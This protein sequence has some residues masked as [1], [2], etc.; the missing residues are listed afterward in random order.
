M[1]SVPPGPDGL[2]LVGNT[3][4]LVR[5]QGGYLERAVQNY[6]PVVSIRMLGAGEVIV[7]ADPDLV[8]SVCFGEEYTKAALA[9]ETLEDLLG[10]GLLLATGEEWRRRRDM[11]QPVFDPD[12]LETY[13]PSMVDRSRA[14]VDGLDPG[15]TYD[16]G[17]EMRRLTFSILLDAVFGTDVE[18]DEYNLQQAA[19]HLLEP[20]KPRKQPIAYTVP[21]WVPIPMWRRY[22]SAIEEFEGVIQT[23][24]DSRDPGEGADFLSMLLTVSDEQGVLTE[25][26]LRDEL[27][28]ML[29]AGH[30]TTATAL[31]FTWQLLGTHPSVDQRLEAELDEVLGEG[32]PT[33]ADL[34]DLEYTEHVVREAMRLYPPVPA[35][36]R[37]PTEPTELGGHQIAEGTTVAPSQWVVHHD[38]DL[39]ED[40]WEF[41]PGRWERRPP[42]DRHRFAYFPF[43]GGPR[44]CI[45]EQFAMMEAKL[46]VATVANRY[47]FRAVDDSPLDPAVSIV[48]QPT[49]SIEIL[50]ERRSATGGPQA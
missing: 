21:M 10:E 36:G 45:G 24:L 12:R 8:E 13:V 40:P 18:Y 47:R 14:F 3:L 33:A 6:G 1:A 15:R 46:V 25:T 22:H 49:R 38:P 32:V 4:G 31:T 26:E 2:P 23:L 34:A 43:G 16:I 41:R 5:E 42:G 50:P 20:G 7:V 35:L 28:T 30:E 39:Y 44:R 29:F 9:Q 19:A 48:T 27:M 17:A 11:I 37:E